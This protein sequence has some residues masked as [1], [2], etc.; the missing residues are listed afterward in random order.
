VLP[1]STKVSTISVVNFIFLLATDRIPGW[2]LQNP[3]CRGTP[4]EKHW[5]VP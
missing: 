1:V 3:R 2:H 5:C 4:L